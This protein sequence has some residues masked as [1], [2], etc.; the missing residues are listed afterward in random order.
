MENKEYSIIHA[1]HNFIYNFPCFHIT[2]FDTIE[3]I[4]SFKLMI[5]Q[6][7]YVLLYDLYFFKKCQ[8]ELILYLK[9]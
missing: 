9:I 1:F 8:D 2:K 4:I 6:Y 5:F 7:K 3:I